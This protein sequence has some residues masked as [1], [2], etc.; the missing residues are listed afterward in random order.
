[1]SCQF[2]DAELGSQESEGGLPVEKVY[3]DAKVI[4]HALEADDTV[5]LQQLL[6]G[7]KAHLSDEPVLVLVEVAVLVEE[8]LLNVGE[9]L[10][11]GLVVAVVQAC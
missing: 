2:M 8:L 6:V 3:G 9:R 10:E 5:A 1:M 4:G 11:K 7:A